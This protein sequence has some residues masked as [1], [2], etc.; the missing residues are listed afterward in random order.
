MTKS[1]EKKIKEKWEIREEFTEKLH[2]HVHFL[3]NTNIIECE[4][5]K[6]WSWFDQKLK[7]QRTQL[8]KEI[9]R[10]TK[11]RNVTKDSLRHYLN[12]LL[13]K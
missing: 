3:G 1:K 12:E 13:N 9:K 4:T 11:G 8:L 6:F 5:E 10:W 2:K 7:E